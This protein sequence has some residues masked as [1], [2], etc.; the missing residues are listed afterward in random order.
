V[1]VLLGH[2]SGLFFQLPGDN[3]NVSDGITEGDPRAPTAPNGRP[4]F[5]TSWR[6]S[7]GYEFGD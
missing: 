4:I 6:A 3:I 7:V 1:G 2:V 5:G